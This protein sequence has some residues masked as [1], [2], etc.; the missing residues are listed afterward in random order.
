[1]RNTKD[2]TLAELWRH[3]KTVASVCRG[4][5][6]HN[7]SAVRLRLNSLDS[8]SLIKVYSSALSE[9]TRDVDK[10]CLEPSVRRLARR[11]R[12]L[13]Q[14]CFKDV[15]SFK[16]EWKRLAEQPDGYPKYQSQCVLLGKDPKTYHEWC[17]IQVTLQ[18]GIR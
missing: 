16:S 9:L 5:R 18:S 15:H 11:R 6:N 13:L 7:A 2:D 4:I 14:A 12:L 1:M 8:A 17:D 10:P 3:S